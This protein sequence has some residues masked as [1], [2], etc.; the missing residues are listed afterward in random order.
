M[1][2]NTQQMY[3]S[4]G[5]YARKSYIPNNFKAAISEHKGVLHCEV[6]D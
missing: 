4:N 1:Y 3:N 2:S 5:L 6:Y